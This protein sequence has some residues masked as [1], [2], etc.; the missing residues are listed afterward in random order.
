MDEAKKFSKNLTDYSYLVSVTSLMEGGLL[1]PLGRVCSC[2]V[3][4]SSSC[5]VLLLLVSFLLLKMAGL[6]RRGKR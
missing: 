3:L 1:H 5:F 6:L 2:A 4:V